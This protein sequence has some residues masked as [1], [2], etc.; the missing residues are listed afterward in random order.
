MCLEYLSVRP[1]YFINDRENRRGNQE[2]TIQ[3]HRTQ[4]T[5]RR[6]STFCMRSQLMQRF[7]LIVLFFT[8]VIYKNGSNS[9]NYI[10]ESSYIITEKKLM[11]FFLRIGSISTTDRNN[12]IKDKMEGLYF[13][14]SGT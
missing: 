5:E 2:C 11:L 7:D 1:L 10:L 4:D 8:V 3:R 13:R 14:R 6:Q 9:K 12:R